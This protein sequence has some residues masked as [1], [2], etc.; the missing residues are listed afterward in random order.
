MNM[1]R[2]SMKYIPREPLV[3]LEELKLELN[4]TKDSMA[5]KRMAEF[6]AMGREISRALEFSKRRKR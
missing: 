6:S 5:F 1:K 2:G 3:E 4:I